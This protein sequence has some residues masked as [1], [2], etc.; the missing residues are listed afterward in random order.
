[1][2]GIG[3]GRLSA[4]HSPKYTRV[5]R[6]RRYLLRVLPKGFDLKAE[7]AQITDNYITATRMRLRKSR[8]VPTNEW[9]LKLTQKHTPAPPDFSRTLITSIYLSEYEYEVFSIFEGNEL[10]KNRYPYEHEGRR[11]SVDVFLGPLRGL[12]LAETDFETDAEMD[13]FPPPSFAFRDVTR[14]EMF[15]GGRLV[16]L[17]SQD[18]CRELA[19]IGSAEGGAQAV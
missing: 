2:K 5:E 13:A 7:H 8:W 11:Y 1:M 19:E 9:T 14:E 15:T 17:T 18:I 10:R 12:I 4:D 3:T 16:E 6:E